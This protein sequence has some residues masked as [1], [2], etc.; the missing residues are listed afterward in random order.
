MLDQKWI[1][2]FY[3]SIGYSI[4]TPPKLYEDNKATI[5]RLFMDM[6]TP[7]ARPLDV[8]ITALH[9]IHLC[10][11][12][13]MVDTRSNICNLLISTPNLMVDKLSGILL[14]LQLVSPCT[15]H[16]GQKTTKLST[17]TYSIG[18]LTIK[19]HKMINTTE[20]SDMNTVYLF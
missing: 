12:F 2:Y 16:Q 18:P 15:L 14:S 17:F 4:G 7:Q 19:N 8:L 3:R 5:K 10:K 11:K 1:R 20:N 6:I 13:D 9:D